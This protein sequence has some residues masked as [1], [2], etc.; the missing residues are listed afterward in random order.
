MTLK[1]LKSFATIIRMVI[2]QRI[3]LVL[4]LVGIFLVKLRLGQ[5]SNVCLLTN[6]SRLANANTIPFE[7]IFCFKCVCGIDKLGF[8]YSKHLVRTFRNVNH[9]LFLYFFFQSFGDTLCTFCFFIDITRVFRPD[10]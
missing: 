10:A 2:T 7:T 3:N 1:L 4:V 5:N 8:R 6:V 9:T